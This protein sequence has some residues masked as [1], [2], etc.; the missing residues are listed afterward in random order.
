[1][2]YFECPEFFSPEGVASIFGPLPGELRWP[3]THSTLV[4]NPTLSKYAHQPLL[5]MG[6]EYHLFR[7]YNYCKFADRD[8]EVIGLRNEL[9][10]YNYRL[11]I[12]LWS[13]Y[14]RRAELFD[15]YI[16]RGVLTLIRCV[17]GF[18][19]RRGYKFVTYAYKSLRCTLTDQDR[20]NCKYYRRFEGLSQLTA[21]WVEDY[22]ENCHNTNRDPVVISAICRAIKA[23]PERMQETLRFRFWEGLTYSEIGRRRGVTKQAAALAVKFA[24]NRVGRSPEMKRIRE[25]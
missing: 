7:K 1:M 22:R 5:T 23:L 13:N 24:I 17:D 3:K 14:N 2:T 19:Y 25:C 6:Q 8:E 18:D 12:S 9:V 10:R 16:Q 15:D 11:V 4:R 20:E 21:G